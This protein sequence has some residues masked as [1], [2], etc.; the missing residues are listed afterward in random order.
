MEIQTVDID[1]NLSFEVSIPDSVLDYKY[2]EAEYRTVGDSTWYKP[3]TWG[4]TRREKVENEKH[5]LIINPQDL[6]KSIEKSMN[7]T[8]E[9]FVGQE[10]ENY[11]NAIIELRRNNS[12]IFQDFRLNKQKEID[13]LQDDIKDSEKNLKVVEKQLED[14]HNLTKE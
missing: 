5:T 12:G 8:I 7:D 4:K 6:K 10:K 1:S 3:W 14:F 11:K 2:Q 13:K 9:I